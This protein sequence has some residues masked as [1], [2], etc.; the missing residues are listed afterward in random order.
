MARRI[1]TPELLV[2]GY[3]SGYF[4][5]ADPADGRIGWFSPDPRAIIPLEGLRVSRSLRRVLRQ[6]P[7]EIFS[8]RDFEGVIRACASRKDTWISEEI[9]GAYTQ[10]FVRGIA[11]TVE[12]WK[13]GRLV[14]GLYGVALGGAFFG[15]SMFSKENDASKI[16]LVELVRRLRT[17]GF[18]L[19]DTQFITEHLRGFGAVEVP[20]DRYLA[21]LDDAL[22]IA[23]RWP[24]REVIRGPNERS[25]V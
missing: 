19:L 21:M 18:T 10:L 16:A 22:T 23:A 13:G 17:G 11:H 14:G 2:H 4:P 3:Q 9:V 7:F 5:M 6:N 20:R 8:D 25:G 1:L 15:E 24:A 12:T